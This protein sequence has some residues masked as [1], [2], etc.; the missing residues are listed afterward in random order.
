M[1]G[2][3]WQKPWA[4]KIFKWAGTLPFFK[5]MGRGS[6]EGAGPLTFCV[7]HSIFQFAT[8][9][10]GVIAYEFWFVAMPLCLLMIWC[11]FYFGATYYMDWFAAKYEAKLAKLTEI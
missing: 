4:V 8:L 6:A 1:Y 11:S 7:C 2:L 10:V 5:M 3:F 9:L